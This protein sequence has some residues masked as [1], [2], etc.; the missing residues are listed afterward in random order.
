MQGYS[1][2]WFSLSL[3]LRKE[4][5]YEEKGRLCHKWQSSRREPPQMAERLIYSVMQACA[6]LW[7]ELIEIRRLCVTKYR[8]SCFAC[9][10]LG[11]DWSAG[12]HHNICSRLERLYKLLKEGKHDRAGEQRAKGGRQDDF[13]L[14]RLW[15]WCSRRIIPMIRLLWSPVLKVDKSGAD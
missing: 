15:W 7:K 1:Y 12:E 10:L 4:E 5:D 3:A 6:P 8:S 9:F 2:L 11:R 13:K 14:S